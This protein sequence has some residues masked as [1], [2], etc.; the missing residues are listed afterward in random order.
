MK[1]KSRKYFELLENIIAIR[2]DKG[3]SQDNIASAI[4]MKQSGYGLIEKGE[5]GLD[6][7]ILITIFL[8]NL[9]FS[10]YYMIGYYTLFENL[11]VFIKL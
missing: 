4:G 6:Y 3:L 11:I 7:E 10:L 1:K 8:K 9:L 2:K 5:R